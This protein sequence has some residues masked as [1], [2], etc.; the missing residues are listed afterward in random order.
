MGFKEKWERFKEV[1]KVVATL[2]FFTILLLFVLSNLE[3]VDIRFLFWGINVPQASVIFT[4]MLMGTLVFKLGE[5][6]QRLLR[7]RGTSQERR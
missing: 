4:S 3:V 5:M 2:V 1:T 6:L 7:K